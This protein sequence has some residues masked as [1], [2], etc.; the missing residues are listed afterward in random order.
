M[1]LF[2]FMLFCATHFFLFLS[3]NI[4]IGTVYFFIDIFFKTACVRLFD[5]FD[6]GW[7]FGFMFFFI[8]TILRMVRWKTVLCFFFFFLRLFFLARDCICC[9]CLVVVPLRPCLFIVE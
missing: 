6:G 9:C 4:I 2:L 3:N 1:F 5:M 8:G 7:C